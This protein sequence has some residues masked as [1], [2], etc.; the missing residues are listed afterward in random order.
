MMAHLAGFGGGRD[1][2]LRMVEEAA[3][4]PSDVQTNARFTLI[5]IYNREARFDD[6]LRRHRRAAAPVPAQSPALARGRQHGA[7]GRPSGRRARVARTRASP[8]SPTILDRARSASW[9]AGATTTAR[10]SWRCRRPSGA[11]R[12]LDEALD[13][14]SRDWVQGRI[15]T[16][17]GKLA[18]LAGD[19]ARA[20]DEYRVAVRLCDDGEDDVCV[21]SA[22]ALMKS[23]Y[24]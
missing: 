21:K 13:D 3:S 6:A 17:L 18:D 2:G 12:A 7:Q 10:R 23:G 14:P 5:V 19:R 1:R 22:K 11:R 20:L 4:Y 9:R 16:E 8:C 24:R 15:H